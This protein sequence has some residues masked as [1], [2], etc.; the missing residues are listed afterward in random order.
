MHDD[1]GTGK[2]QNAQD[3]LVAVLKPAERH[4]CV[5]WSH[6]ST[7]ACSAKVSDEISLVA[8]S[9]AAADCAAVAAVQFR[10][11]AVER[12]QVVRRSDGEWESGVEHVVPRIVRTILHSALAVL[13][14][15]EGEYIARAEAELVACKARTTAQ[16]QC[17]ETRWLVIWILLMVFTSGGRYDA[18][19]RTFLRALC[20]LY[21]I[22]H[23]KLLAAEALRLDALQQLLHQDGSPPGH[24]TSG[25]GGT[26]GSHHTSGSGNAWSAGR[27]LKVG[28]AAVAG[29]AAL[30]I[31]GGAAAPALGSAFSAVGAGQVL[32]TAGGVQAL[33]GAAGAGMSAAAV[34]NLTGGV[35]EFAIDAPG[36]APRDHVQAQHSEPEP[37]PEL[38]CVTRARELHVAGEITDAEY[39]AL[40]AV[41][42]K[43]QA[44]D[45]AVASDSGSRGSPASVTANS[46]GRVSVKTLHAPQTNSF[47]SDPLRTSTP[48]A[49][50]DAPDSSCTGS[51]V[52]RSTCGLAVVIGVSGWLADDGKD[53]FETQW[54]W[55]SEELPGH[56]CK[57][58]R[59]ESEALKELGQQFRN[60]VKSKVHQ[61][62]G[63][64]VAQELTVGMEMLEFAMVEAFAWPLVLLT[65]ASYIDNAW[66][67]ACSRAVK[68]GR[69]LAATL[70]SRKYGHRPVILCGYSTGALL[71]W[72][73][74]EEIANAPDG[75]GE[76]IIESVFLMGAPVS[77]SAQRWTK[78]RKV[79]AGRLVNGYNRSDWVLW[80]L[81]RS[82]GGALVGEIA[83]LSPVAAD[84]GV[85][86][87]DLS[88][89]LLEEKRQGHRQYH[90]K[91]RRVLQA[92]GLGGDQCELLWALKKRRQE[93][94]EELSVTA[95]RISVL[96]REQERRRFQLEQPH[97]QGQQEAERQPLGRSGSDLQINC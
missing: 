96:A 94:D 69:M 1:T 91:F 6:L 49:V 38:D 39:A 87:I 32:T 84:I 41:F 53:S 74:L 48:T 78:V 17:E 21:D 62:I 88:L 29:S 18:R 4:L 60:F 16:L 71:I 55:L 30:F 82:I 67:M 93:V 59:W 75:T 27:T 40:L 35:Q 97:Q 9:A 61:N 63:Y 72:T 2:Q 23:V 58:V 44:E 8:R 73:C 76:G 31:S 81:Q 7:G 85:E 56:E 42:A 83:G 66:S 95:R 43:E 5:T 34:K 24:A 57:W 90:S 64:T 14:V 26:V 22:P 70:L 65:A 52:G 77:A 79:V 3:H 25:D 12:Q 89:L 50:P 68:A 36:H 45:P 33:F 47:G 11:L 20:R 10:Y 28:G 92:L 15:A 86:S 51:A 19:M 46:A 54:T 80:M 37:E 13:R